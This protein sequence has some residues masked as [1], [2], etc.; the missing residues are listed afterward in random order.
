MPFAPA[1]KSEALQ[2]RLATLRRELV[3]TDRRMLELC[4]GIEQLELGAKDQDF[5]QN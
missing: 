4:E 3:D 5:F 1:P 2:D